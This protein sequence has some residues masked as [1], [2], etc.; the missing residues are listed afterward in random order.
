MVS[1]INNIDAEKASKM[2]CSMLESDIPDSFKEIIAESLNVDGSIDENEIMNIA[3]ILAFGDCSSDVPKEAREFVVLVY[4]DEIDQ[5]NEVAMLNLGSLYY[6]GRIGEQSYKQAIYYYKM[7]YAKGNS[8]AS[9]NL[10]YCYYY[11]RD[12]EVDYKKAY[13]YFI[14]PAL[15]GRTE[16]M[17]K[18]GDMYAKGLYVEKDEYYA[19]TIYEKAYKDMDDECD[20]KADVCLRMGNSFYYGN[21]CERDLTTALFFYQ[22]AEFNYYL[23]ISNGDS[24]KKKMLNNVIEKINTIRNEL[25]LEIC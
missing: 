8:I 23:Q 17:Y 11:G 3:N 19:F 24:F 14:K 13:H 6:T 22:Q 15:L 1:G 5:D 25:K 9:E 21:G 4:L 7:A 10:G 18:I 2:L 20:V 12:V 16:S